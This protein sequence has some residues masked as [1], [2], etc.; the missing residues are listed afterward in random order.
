MAVL[1]V[2]VNNS[3]DLLVSFTPPNTTTEEP[4]PKG[5][6]VRYNDTDGILG[7]FAPG[8]WGEWTACQSG[9]QTRERFC[10]T[11]PPLYSGINSSYQL[12]E[13]R[14]CGNLTELVTGR[15]P[16]DW[17][18]F[19]DYCYNI[20]S[21]TMRKNWSDA[22]ETCLNINSDLV[23]ITSKDE[24]TFVFAFLTEKIENGKAWIGL[25][26]DGK[27]VWSDGS[28]LT[29]FGQLNLQ[30][31]PPFC[32]LMTRGMQWSQRLCSRKIKYAVCK[33]RAIFDDDESCLSSPLG[34]ETGVITQQQM[35]AKSYY[36]ETTLPHYARLA[37]HGAWCPKQTPN[38]LQIDLII[39][40]CIC[41]VAT[42]GHYEQGSF[43]TIYFLVLKTGDRKD[44]YK[45]ASG[46]AILQGNS[47][48]YEVHINTLADGVVADQVRFQKNTTYCVT[49]L[50]FDEYGEGPA[51]NCINVTIRDGACPVSW[52]RH[53]DS[54][55]LVISKPANWTQ[56]KQGCLSRNSQLLTIANNEEN[57]FVADLADDVSWIGA[58]WNELMKDYN[59]VDGSEIGFT[60]KWIN[61]TMDSSLCVGICENVSFD[62]QC[63]SVGEWQ[64]DQ[65]VHLKSFVCEREVAHDAENETCNNMAV[66]FEYGI[67]YN[68][69]LTAS[70][71]LHNNAPSNA[72]LAGEKA[73]CPQTNSS[74]EYLEVTFKSLHSI[75]ALATQ[76]LHE[77]GAYTKTYR[78]QF[79]TD[80]LGLTWEWYTHVHNNGS[81]EIIQGNDNSYD[82]VKQ[83]FTPYTPTA[84]HVRIWPVSFCVHPCLRI[85]LY[86]EP[87]KTKQGWSDW[88][89]WSACSK[90]CGQG[91]QNRT[92]ECIAD[93][94]CQGDE[95]E[96]KECIMKNCTGDVTFLNHPY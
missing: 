5:Y 23:S 49:V 91:V 30:T 67:M 62:Q 76:G 77:I 65:C 19:N 31:P 9:T 90:T 15:C 51:E 86:G 71:S 44:Y 47:N 3:Q 85:E 21:Y 73:W 7:E 16:K 70:S 74:Y 22:R 24:D 66:G 35:K 81:G 69:S 46:N 13:T 4:I 37:G 89:L 55:Y 95:S 29:Y 38:W 57:K 53:G 17:D 79:S 83:E 54:C 59:W 34:V 28:N 42:Q 75:C 68:D 60:K 20:N 93:I 43:T 26:N 52:K 11:F 61:K 27:N 8:E 48:P 50:A 10:Q 78:L 92:R 72:R 14:K 39:I 94:I 63:G 88:G 58:Q 2:G 56:A 96:E 41:A 45:A 64:Q 33:R 32:V 82:V 12:N 6:L 84:L 25:R 36:N 18:Y 80:G 87:V 40:H 1:H